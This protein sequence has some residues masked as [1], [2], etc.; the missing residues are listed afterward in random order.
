MPAVASPHIGELAAL[1]TAAC[2]T[3]TALSFEAAGKRVGSLSVNVIR[4]VIAGCLLSIWG[5]AT[6]G[7]WLPVDASAH[8]WTWLSASAVAGFLVGDF[9]LFRAFIVL[10]PRL[11]ALVMSTVPVWTALFGF[12]V[13][14]E[15]LT[16]VDAAAMALVV[17]GIA[18]AVTDRPRPGESR[19]VNLQG[20]LLALGGSLGQAGGLVLSKYGMGDYDAFAATQIRV[21]AGIAGFFVVCTVIGWWPRLVTAV[22]D[23]AAMKYTFIGAFFGPFLGVGLSLLSVQV[24]P[25]TGVAAAIMA[26]TPIMLIPAVML[27][28]DRVGLGGIGGALL[29]VGGVA[30]LFL[31]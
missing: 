27:Q 13:L 8:N 23:R 15:G 26:T 25:N 4:L 12:I 3:F 30:L 6:R 18:W 19:R 5:A 29:A 20:L 11:S 7:L 14:D 16:G 31:T 28:G 2:W 21:L 24:S 1:G 17:G 10:G 22:R 9:C